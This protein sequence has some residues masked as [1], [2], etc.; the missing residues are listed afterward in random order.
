[1]FLRPFFLPIHLIYLSQFYVCSVNWT[2][3]SKSQESPRWVLKEKCSYDNDNND[4]K[5]FT[6][7]SFM[8]QNGRPSGLIL[9]NTLGLGAVLPRVHLP[10]GRTPF[11]PEVR[12]NKQRHFLENSCRKSSLIITESWRK[13]D[14]APRTRR[15]SL[16][17]DRCLWPSAGGGMAWAEVGGAQGTAEAHGGPDA[18]RCPRGLWP[19]ACTCVSGERGGPWWGWM[20]GCSHL[21]R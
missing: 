13:W 12:R 15:A 21:S 19:A 9:K 16:S 6:H 8:L 2:I 17:R 10:V 3:G 18:L 14:E 7:W 5:T 4:E 11:V 20:R 1:M